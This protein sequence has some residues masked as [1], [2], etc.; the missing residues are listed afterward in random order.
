MQKSQQ[1][2]KKLSNSEAFLRRSETQRKAEQKVREESERL[3][4][5]EREQ[6]AE[7]RKCDMMLHARVAAKAEE[8]SMELLYIHWTEHHK[9]LSNFLR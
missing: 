1:E 8:K 9:R 4:Q 3:R 5:Q 6:I 7:K 2:D